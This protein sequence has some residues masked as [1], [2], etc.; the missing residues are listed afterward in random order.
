MAEEAAE[1][2]RATLE[3]EV[4]LVGVAAWRQAR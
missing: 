2:P 1:P 3:E 4:S